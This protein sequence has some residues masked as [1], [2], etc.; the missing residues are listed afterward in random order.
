VDH[1][2]TETERTFTSLYLTTAEFEILCAFHGI[3]DEETILPIRDSI[4]QA[5]HE[6]LEPELLIYS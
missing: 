4:L 6:G 2:L 5:T 1:A 3:T